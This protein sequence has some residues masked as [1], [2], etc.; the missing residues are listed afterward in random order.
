MVEEVVL[1]VP[2][3][4]R[5]GRDGATIILVP[6]QYATVTVPYHPGIINDVCMYC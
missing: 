1:Y 5:G 6:V 4:G 3:L 2:Y